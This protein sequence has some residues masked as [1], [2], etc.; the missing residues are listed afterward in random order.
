MRLCFLAFFLFLLSCSNGDYF[1]GLQIEQDLPEQDLSFQA[2]RGELEREEFLLKDE[3]VFVDFL[4][5]PDAS[6]SMYHHLSEVGRSLSDLFFF[7]TDYNWQLS[8]TSVDHG[9]HEEPQGLQQNWRDYIQAPHGK[10][11]NLMSFENERGDINTKIL[12]AFVPDYKSVFFH[13]LSHVHSIDCNR[14]PHCSP[15]LEQPLRSLK[16]AMERANLNNNISFRPQADLIVLYIG[17]EEERFE[18]RKRATSP[19]E[20]LQT[21][22]EIF[23]HL[24]KNFIVFNILVTDES[25]LEREKEHSDRVSIGYSLMELADQTGGENISICSQ[26]YGKELRKISKHIKNTLQNSITL[27]KKPLPESLVLEFSGKKLDWE[28]YDRTIVFERE[29][30]SSKSIEVQVSYE[31]WD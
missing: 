1:Q 25:C 26:N 27:K 2:S 6:A 31:R 3:Q 15:R 10:F 5:L 21:F 18:D 11:G 16:A 19:K 30:F 29:E 13:T 28:L 20:V 7:I 14:P 4:I 22:D 17:N 24:D 23:G 8:I 12:N 9:D